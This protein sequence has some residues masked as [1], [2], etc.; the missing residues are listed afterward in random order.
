MSSLLADIGNNDATG[1]TPPC[2][3]C[4]SPTRSGRQQRAGG[5]LLPLPL[6]SPP[7]APGR[8]QRRSHVPGRLPY[9]IDKTTRSTTYRFA[10]L[11]RARWSP[12]SSADAGRLGWPP[13]RQPLRR[14]P[15]QRP[16]TAGG[17]EPHPGVLYQARDPAPRGQA[18]VADLIARPPP[19]TI[20]LGHNANV[21]GI[22]FGYRSHDLHLLAENGNLYLVAADVT[23]DSRA[24]GSWAAGPRGP[25]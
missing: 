4:A 1:M 16:A 9:L 8:P 10:R 19:W 14:R 13:A 2:C 6:S 25:R 20:S 21:E 15:V 11:T 3:G 18:L 7:G 23:P 22:A 5:R 24:R 17:P 12:L